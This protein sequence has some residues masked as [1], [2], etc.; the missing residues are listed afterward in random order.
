[1]LKLL[2]VFANNSFNIDMCHFVSLYIACGSICCFATRY[3]L[4]GVK[5]KGAIDLLLQSNIS[6]FERS[7]KYI[8]CSPSEQIS[9][10]IATYRHTAGVVYR[11]KRKDFCKMTEPTYKDLRNKCGSIRRRLISSITTAKENG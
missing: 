10:C 1:M 5:E 4:R 6:N 9:S 8:D 2:F 7:K 11:Q 3:A